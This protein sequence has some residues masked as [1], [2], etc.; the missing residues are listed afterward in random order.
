MS[1]ADSLVQLWYFHI[2]N[3][4]LAVMLYATIGRFALGLFVDENWSNYIWRGFKAVSHPAVWV[5]RRVTPTAVPHPV[6]LGFTMIWLMA[7]R[8]ALFI[9][10]AAAGLLPRVQA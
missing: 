5:V 10:L 8:V 1:V 6:V 3:Y 9:G 2:P 4:A 7:A